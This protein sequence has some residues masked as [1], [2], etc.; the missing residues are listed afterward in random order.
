MS[1]V[2]ADIGRYRIDRV[3]GRGGMALVYLG[4]DAN[5]GRAVAIKLLAD[6][7]AGDESFRARFLREARMA[8]GLS[9]VNIVHVY[10]VGQDED[11][12]PYIVMEFVDGESLAETIA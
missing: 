12:R 10:D 8:A 7:L 9:H 5:L 1:T 2:R 4:H 6:N 11:E 3:L